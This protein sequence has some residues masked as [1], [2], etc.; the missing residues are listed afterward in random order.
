MLSW[1][2]ST[3]AD[4]AS[5]DWARISDVAR[6]NLWR[7][8]S[9]HRWTMVLNRATRSLTLYFDSKDG[10]LVRALYGDRELKARNTRGLVTQV[11]RILEG[12]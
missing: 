6:D 7:E 11:V 5:G 12:G 8:Y 10:S 9:P 2:S 3:G 1:L 4:V